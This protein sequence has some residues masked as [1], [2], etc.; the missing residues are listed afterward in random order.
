[1][2]WLRADTTRREFER[3]VTERT[4]QLL[5]TAYLMAWDLAEAED[6]VQETLL[7]VARR[8]PKVR[9]MEHPAAYARKLLV[10][11]AIDSAQKR[12]RVA[13]ADGQRRSLHLDQAGLCEQTG[14]VALA[15]AGPVR[16][17][18]GSGIQLTDG[19][20]EH[21]QRPAITRVVPHARR[22]EAARLGDPCHLSQPH[23]RV[24]H[25]VDDPLRQRHVERALG[26]GQ[27]LRC[28]QAHVH[29][30][31]SFPDRRHERRRRLSRAHRAC[32]GPARQL[33]RQRSGPHPTSRT[34]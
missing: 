6:L 31:K 27:P 3:F 8:W 26:E 14:Q 22:G 15:G 13:N 28:R 20:P 19:P 5:R 11:L 33:S 2:H 4:D 9:T 34:R 32:P 30:G 25:E 21:S 1:M 10:N 29:A 12:A 23:H 16:Q 18:T 17:L 24:R 7:Q